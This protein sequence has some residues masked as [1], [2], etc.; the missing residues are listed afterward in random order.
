MNSPG[1]KTSFSMM[2]VEREYV[3]PPK[4]KPPTFLSISYLVLRIGL[5]R[6]MALI[7]TSRL[8]LKPCSLYALAALSDIEVAVGASYYSTS[9]SSS[10]V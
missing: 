10:L 4:M 9:L 5:G 6:G 2:I 1:V 8:T 7:W 3:P